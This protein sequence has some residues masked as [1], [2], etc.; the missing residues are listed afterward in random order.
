MIQPD[1]STNL[2]ALGQDAVEDGVDVAEL[3]LQVEALLQLVGE[4]QR[5]HVGVGRQQGAEVFTFVPDL[6]CI[7][8]YHYIS[9]LP[10]HSFSISCKSTGCEKTRPFVASRFSSIRAG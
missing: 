9:L 8:L 10:L 1:K 3:V 2:A 6:H 5:L 4:Q 7:A